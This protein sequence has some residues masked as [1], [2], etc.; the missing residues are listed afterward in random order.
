MYRVENNME[1]I[2]AVNRIFDRQRTSCR[3]LPSY[4][5][6]LQ[7][8]YDECRCS[9]IVQIGRFNLLNQYKNTGC[10]IST[11][12]KGF[13]PRNQ[14]M[15]GV[16]HCDQDER[17]NESRFNIQPDKITNEDITCYSFRKKKNNAT[18]RNFPKKHMVA[19][20]MANEQVTEI[21]TNVQ[22]RQQLARF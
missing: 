3:G 19:T 16:Q 14:T 5:G 15:V 13:R 8:T 18:R 7:M 4:P 22:E 17:T 20:P 9:K 6:L 11:T 12:L 21:S 1:A 2:Q 10:Y